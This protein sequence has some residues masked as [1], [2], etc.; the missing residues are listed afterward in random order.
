MA[1][2]S[3][4]LTTTIHPKLLLLLLL[5]GNL[6]MADKSGLCLTCKSCRIWQIWSLPYQLI[7]AGKSDCSWEIWSWTG[8]Q[9][10]ASKSC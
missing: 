6:V 5:L 9:A 1:G 4:P 2:K 8:N 7:M 3:G 10:V